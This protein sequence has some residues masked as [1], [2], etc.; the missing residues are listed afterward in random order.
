MTSP[1]ALDRAAVAHSRRAL[2]VLHACGYRERLVSLLEQMPEMELVAG[3]GDPARALEDMLSFSP[4]VVLLDL[5]LP[6]HASFGL[7]DTLHRWTPRPLIIGLS[8][9]TYPAHRE[10]CLALGA[11]C[12]LDKAHELDRLAEAMT[13]VSPLPPMFETT[14][15]RAEMRRLLS[16]LNYQIL[17]T[18]TERIY[19]DLVELAAQLCGTPIALISLFEGDRQWFKSRRGLD[20]T[21]IPRTISFCA[22]TL[23]GDGTFVVADAVTDSRFR[24]NP[25]VHGPS[26]VRFYAGVPLQAEDGEKL[27]TLCV[28]DHAV[29]ELSPA[30]QAGLRALGRQT[31]N[32]LECRRLAIDLKRADEARTAA[33]Q[34]LEYL[35]TR[36][37]LTGLDNRL[38]F[39]Y[40]F[41]TALKANARQRA[42]LACLYLDLDNFKLVNDS[43]GHRAGDALLVEASRRLRATVR[44]TDVV[45]RLGGDEFAVALTGVDT[46]ESIAHVAAKIV[47]TLSAPYA[48]TGQRV[49]VG[50]S[51][52]ISLSPGD[53]S[54]TDT[55][56]QQADSALYHAKHLGKAGFQFFTP[57]LN[58][59][60]TER[61]RLE[62]ELRSA[63][64]HEEFEL[65]FQPQIELASGRLAG[66]EALLRW[67][68]ADRVVSPLEILPLI[69]ELHL[70]ARLGDWVLRS[71]LAR[72]A[73]WRARGLALPKLS[74][75]VTAAE[76]VADYATRVLA[77]LA[78]YGVPPEVLEIEVTESQMLAHVDTAAELF[79]TLREAGVRIALDDFG[80]G[81]SALSM[82]QALTFDTLKIDRSFTAE[83]AGTRDD[84]T[85]LGAIVMLGRRL[86]L[87][88]VAEGVEDGRQV[89]TLRALGCHDYQGWFSSPALPAQEFE[90]RF[91]RPPER[92]RWPAS[93][94]EPRA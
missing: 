58:A 65:Y 52:G 60:I 5:D 63:L 82:L 27:G 81:Y 35:A 83:I 80:T 3:T 45:A 1:T 2:V 10:R 14:L 61:L 41:D 84:P 32:L 47:A 6:E 94:Q 75:N 92:G 11:D 9:H 91:L 79:A 59:R 71:A 18:P 67:P 78:T 34:K 37:A 69:A 73:D 86:G 19:D 54:D 8:S 23:A 21:E 29:R 15:P 48:I 66:A 74:V 53:G 30:Q 13:R 46:V 42:L 26:G 90:A 28:M 7:L 31:M 76:L 17:D 22:H 43:L 77:L 87:H 16:L 33:E 12:F 72:Y 89:E 85:I 93:R 56:L 88:L 64:E 68:R 25:L 24:D 39:H 49:H 38:S 36:D 20:L 40:C 4:N 57:A 50:C 55:L 51:I 44:D 70:D 62:D